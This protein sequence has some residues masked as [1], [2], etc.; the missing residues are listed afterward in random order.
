MLGA[1]EGR[2]AAG[3]GETEGEGERSLWAG[4]VTLEK[5]GAEANLEGWGELP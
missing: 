4:G 3:L 1:G 5:V 2:Q